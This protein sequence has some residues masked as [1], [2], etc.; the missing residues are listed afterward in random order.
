MVI[1]NATATRIIWS[2]TDQGSSLVASAVEYIVDD[3]P[4]I[5]NVTREAILA[6]GTI[7]SPKILELSGVGSSKVLKAAG[8]QPV[9]EIPTVGENLAGTPL[10][11]PWYAT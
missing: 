7:G 11:C 8:V 10:F 9:L 2:E 5:V 3:Q 1:T 4:V 6:S